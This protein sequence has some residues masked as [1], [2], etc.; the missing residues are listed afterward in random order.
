MGVL[1]VLLLFSVAFFFG[2][3]KPLAVLLLVVFF[4]PWQGVDIDVGL[5]VTAYRAL[6]FGL[7]SSVIMQTLL[8]RIRL[9]ARA[10]KYTSLFY[11]YI[12]YAALITFAQLPFIPELSISGGELRSPF[13]RSIIQVVIFTVELSPLFL[14]PM[15]VR[16]ESIRL[17]AEV[18]IKSVII[19]AVLGWIQIFSN[20]VLGFDPYPIGAVNQWFGGNADHL[21]QGLQN[22]G[23]VQVLRMNS[24]A[25]EPRH[26]GIALSVALLMLQVVSTVSKKN[27]PKYAQLIWWFLFTSMLE[28]FSASASYI[29]I[30]GS[31]LIFIFSIVLRKGVSAIKIVLVFSVFASVFITFS[32]AINDTLLYK[33]FYVRVIDRDAIEDFDSAVLGYLEENPSAS[34]TGVGLGNI[35][36][37]AMDYLSEIVKLYAYGNVFTAK[38]GYLRIISEIGIIGIIILFLGFW[39]ISRSLYY[40]GQDETQMLWVMGWVLFMCF[41]M[42]G[43]FV[44]PQFFV[45]LGL[46]IALLSNRNERD[47]LS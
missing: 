24:F 33:V 4:A 17:V 37:Y 20:Y 41:L 15:I 12:F 8:G 13:M 40:Q 28:T 32:V 30:A 18:Y 2:F 5:R 26:L 27:K 36:L 22:M 21:R 46:S 6:L 39:K 23:S 16:G 43:A 25:G 47:R 7:F 35:H 38:S 3:K 29:W 1:F 10:N 45:L 9:P 11:L 44:G 42:R 19:L 31:L 34:I 14:V